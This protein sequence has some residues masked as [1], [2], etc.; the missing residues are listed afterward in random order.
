MEA[1]HQASHCIRP[2]CVWVVR[3]TWVTTRH[4]SVV[5]VDVPA[6]C[7]TVVQIFERLEWGGRFR[8]VLAARKSSG[9]LVRRWGW[10]TSAAG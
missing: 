3:G 9:L 8:W 7:M 1:C 6:M 2:C 5:V 10:V 4:A